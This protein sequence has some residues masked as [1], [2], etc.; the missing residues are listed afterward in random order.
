[1]TL[2][3]VSPGGAPQ[4]PVGAPR[5]SG[6]R[7]EASQAEGTFAALLAA[8]APAATH[9]DAA[10]GEAPVAFEGQP[11][12]TGAGLSGSVQALL[13]LPREGGGQAA[14][15]PA[16]AADA[17]SADGQGGTAPAA[18]SGWPGE[19]VIE[20]Q[21]V[22]DQIVTDQPAEQDPIRDLLRMQG[23]EPFGGKAG[24]PGTGGPGQGDAT[25]LIQEGP[26][27]DGAAASGDEAAPAARPVE[28][29][30]GQAGAGEVVSAQPGLTA[31]PGIPVGEAAPAGEGAPADD[32]GLA[33]EGRQPEAVS[34]PVPDVAPA[35]APDPAGGAQP[36]A[37]AAAARG[38]ERLTAGRLQAEQVM[39]ELARTVPELPDGQYRLTLRLHPEHLGEVRLELHLNGRDVYAAME[40]VS[41]DARQALESRGEQLRQGLSDAGY[42][43]AGFDVATGEG[44]QARHGG[45]E[46]PAGWSRPTGRSRGRP[47]AAAAPAAGVRPAPGPRSGRLDTLA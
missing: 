17:A 18:Q 36:V 4:P 23:P 19:P 39:A 6:R 33:G 10:A 22:V 2:P 40:V 43:L 3:V 41:S 11:H 24:P 14:L 21:A 32:G 16:L 5:E 13:G 7:D 27:A 31:R 46:E 47:E 9:P 34:R 26:V 45:A 15:P 35:P 25:T 8:L 37:G 44:R 1:M 20:W 42:N 12:V 38:L 30:G 28:V 29:P